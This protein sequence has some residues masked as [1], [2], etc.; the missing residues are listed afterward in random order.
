MTPAAQDTARRRAGA[1]T[2]ARILL[3]PG[4]TVGAEDRA[5][6]D[7]LATKHWG[8]G[9]S[10]AERVAAKLD[11]LPA[12]EQARILWKDDD[13]RAFAAFRTDD[14]TRPGDPIQTAT[15]LLDVCR[16]DS[17]DDLATDPDARAR[18]ESLKSAFTTWAGR[19][20]AQG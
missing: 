10:L 2:R 12:P 20:P 17:A 7:K 19:L 14:F 1:A 6:L 16:I 9:A 3:A 5:Y 4:A 13:F 8:Y 18:F 15:F 11:G